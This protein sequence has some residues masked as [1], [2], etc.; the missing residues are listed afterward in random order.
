MGLKIQNLSLS[1]GEKKIF[2]S[3][4]LEIFLGEILIVKGVNGSGKTSFLR[5][6][7]GFFS[8]D[9]NHK[10][11]SSNLY[12]QKNSHEFF[13]DGKIFCEEFDT[14][15]HQEKY[16]HTRSFIPANFEFCDEFDVKFYLK[17]WDKINQNEDEEKKIDS[18]IR[19]FGLEPFLE[20]EIREISSGWKK[21]LQYSK[22]IFENRPIWILDE[23]LNFLDND[24]K[25]LIIGMINAKILSGGIVILSDHL[26]EIEKFL[27]FEAEENR[28]HYLNL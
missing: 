10:T 6:L 2:D 26:D 21:R 9:K 18:A 1:F 27:N 22:L 15:E 23:P 24:G 11:Q 25:S 13:L 8:F 12:F 16:F 5:S 3:I 7:A 14:S 28:I 17:F 20:N 19:Y 4:N